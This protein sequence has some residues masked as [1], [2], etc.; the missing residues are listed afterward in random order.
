[1]KS[2]VEKYKRPAKLS[3]C[4]N[5]KH[6]KRLGRAL[7]GSNWRSLPQHQRYSPTHLSTG[8]MGD[9]HVGHMHHQ[10]HSINTRDY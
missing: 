8:D 5:T 6:V 2:S 10:T 9:Q 4:M 7:G 3:I 1:M